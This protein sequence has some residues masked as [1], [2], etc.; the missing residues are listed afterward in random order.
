MLCWFYFHSLNKTWNVVTLE[1]IFKEISITMT[2]L[3]GN[4]QP[5][6]QQLQQHQQSHRQQQN[7]TKWR[8]RYKEKMEDAKK[9]PIWRS[10]MLRKGQ[11]EHQWEVMVS[12]SSLKPLNNCLRAVTRRW[13]CGNRFSGH[14]NSHKRQ[15]A[16]IKSSERH[17]NDYNRLEIIK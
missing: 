2:L 10:F 4:R 16:A 3:S 15:D 5:F 8:L 17:R 7:K 14:L 11:G 6:K 12:Q 1:I 13:W 9:K